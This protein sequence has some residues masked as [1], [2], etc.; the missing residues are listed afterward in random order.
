MNP[1]T[2]FA[3]VMADKRRDLEINFNTINTNKIQY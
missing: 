2:Q 1:I 3:N